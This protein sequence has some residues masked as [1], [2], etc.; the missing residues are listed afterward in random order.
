M[1]VKFKK[2]SSNACIPTKS[3]VRSAC[4]DVYSGKDFESWF[5]FSI[6]EEV[7][8]QKEEMHKLTHKIVALQF[9]FARTIARAFNGG[10]ENKEFEIFIINESIMELESFLGKK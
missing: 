10:H 3:T 4:F 8:L 7:C 1:K 6:F 5:R 9:S 2:F